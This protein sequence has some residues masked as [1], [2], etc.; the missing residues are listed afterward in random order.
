MKNRNVLE[1]FK[2]AMSGIVY[3]VKNERNMKIH[4]MASVGI[5]LLSFLLPLSKVEWAVICLTVALV[6]VCE[7]FN[8]AME[9]MVNMLVD[10]YHPKVKIIKDVAAGAVFLSAMIAIGIG[11]L[12]F[13]D[14]LVVFI[15]NLIV[16]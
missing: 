7:L 1:S 5:M 14:K 3:A 12:I 6:L 11:Y 16:Y 8:T 4:V 9:V 13:F 2:N 10:V 15:K